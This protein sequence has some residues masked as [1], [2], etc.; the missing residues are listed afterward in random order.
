MLSDGRPNFTN[1]KGEK[2]MGKMLT[3]TPNGNN[4]KLGPGVATT[5]R[6]VGPTCPPDCAMA[7]ACYAN[8]GRVAI[9]AKRSEGRT[10]ALRAAAANTLVRHVVSGDWFREGADGRKLVDSQ[11]LLEAIELH[12]S[13]P[14]LTGWG[15]THGADRLYRAG[16][17]PESWPVNF[18]IL[19]SCQDADE[20]ERLN[21]DGWQT[22]RVIEEKTD[23]LP[24][25]SLCPADTQKRAGIPKEQRT[26]CARCR[27]CFDGKNR[28]IA[29]L[30]F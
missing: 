30:R 3:V 20:K 29:F 13:C 14:W 18:R 16:F 24:D 2:L 12:E 1:M 9:H 17:G 7:S 22:A 19:A 21:K 26:T 28:N 11:L 5:Y 15:Y 10:D 27:M 8:R 6:P 23:K 4:G 25:E